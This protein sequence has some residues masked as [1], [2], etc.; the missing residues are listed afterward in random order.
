MNIL[1]SGIEEKA[2]KVSF[3]G[4]RSLCPLQYKKPP[5][6]KGLIIEHRTVQDTQAEAGEVGIRSKYAH[7]PAGYM[8]TLFSVWE[9]SQKK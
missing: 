4:P 5:Y 3:L 7:P 1:V 9:H 6:S 2:R 8:S